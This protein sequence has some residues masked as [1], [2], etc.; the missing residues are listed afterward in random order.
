MLRRTRPI[1]SSLVLCAL[2]VA[3]SGEQ[4]KT[5]AQAIMDSL[6]ALDA[7]NPSLAIIELKNAIQFHPRDP[8]LRA[9][10]AETFLRIGDPGSAEIEAAKAKQLGYDETKSQLLIAEAMISQDQASSA[11]ER[12]DA[13][14]NLAPADDEQRRQLLMARAQ[15]ELGNPEQAAEHIEATGE[16]LPAAQI[17][18]ARLTAMKGNTEAAAT[19]LEELLKLHPA[20]ADAWSLLADIRRFQGKPDEAIAAL[21][22]SVEFGLNTRR[23]RWQRALLNLRQGNLDAVVDDMKILRGRD[24]EQPQAA[25]LEGVIE[26]QREN[27]QAAQTL[28]QIAHSKGPDFLPTAYYLA[29]SHHRLKEYN[30]AEQ[31]LSQYVSALPDDLHGRQ[32]RALNYWALGNLDLAAEQAQAMLD[33]ENGNAFA[34]ELL[35]LYSMRQGDA[36]GAVG[37]LERLNALG[38]SGDA[39]DLRLGL[40]YLRAGQKQKGMD[41]LKRLATRE[42]TWSAAADETLILAEIAEHRLDR[43][44]DMAVAMQK[45]YPELAR[46]YTLMGTALSEMGDEAGAIEAFEKAWSLEPGEVITGRS[47]ARMHAKRGDLPR[48]LSLYR[49]V[50]AAHPDS[51]VTRVELAQTLYYT[52]DIQEFVAQ[53][54][55]AATND[56]KDPRPWLLLLR[57]D[58][59]IKD[60][61]TALQRIEQIPNAVRNTAGFRE[62]AGAVYLL[63]G[64]PQLAVPMFSRLV[65]DFPNNAQFRLQLAQALSASGEAAQSLSVLETAIQRFPGNLNLETALANMELAN[66]QLQQAQE[67]IA[68]IERSGQNPLAVANIKGRLALARGDLSQAAELL[69]KALEL[70]PSAKAAFPLVSTY[71]AMGRIG[72]AIVLAESWT[73]KEPNDLPLLLILGDLYTRNNA[74]AKAIATYRQVLAAQPSHPVANNNLAWALLDS[75]PVTALQHAERAYVAA[76][77]TSTIAD[78]YG[79]ILHS[80]GHSQRALEILEKAARD[81]KAGQSLQEHLAIVRRAVQA[82]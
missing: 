31:Y 24:K 33:R 34:L 39:L 26:I 27:Y 36:T 73:A 47:L 1:V 9:Q 16:D 10:M 65:S 20:N 55:Q 68:M 69:A 51:T 25:F 56:P 48:A 80:N 22:N 3:C 45:K 5:P 50:L 37:A 23:D 75:D 61:T 63:A 12:L 71:A 57:H 70:Q 44:V 58:L 54:S 7:R 15:L 62:T 79:W 29:V 81:P 18:N 41:A 13:L 46:P 66:G 82:P 76:P 43:A 28:L 49:E 74:S 72:D 32:L 35:S 59:A 42:S 6:A 77:Q 53:L 64:R 60:S 17:V 8:Y 40:S 21:D 11:Y 67:R 4:E 14:N 38:E 30:L 2:L 78:T 19:Q 52:G